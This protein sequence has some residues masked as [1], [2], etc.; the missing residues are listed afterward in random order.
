MTAS[1][2]AMVDAWGLDEQGTKVGVVAFSTEADLGAPLTADRGVI[3]A[4]A[5]KAI[6]AR[7]AI[8]VSRVY[9]VTPDPPVLT[10]G[11]FPGE[12]I[13]HWTLGELGD[14]YLDTLNAGLY[15]P[16]VGCGRTSGW[17]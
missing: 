9:Q 10:E 13:P 1:I 12:G 6:L 15:G 17:R 2:L 3:A 4:A 5:P 8:P 7:K 14:F 16:R 11:R